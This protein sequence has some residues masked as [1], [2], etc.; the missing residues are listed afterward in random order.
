[1]KKIIAAVLIV[2][3]LVLV[4]LLGIFIHNK[5][6]DN[7]FDK[8]R[9]CVVFKDQSEFDKNGDYIHFLNT[10]SSD[11]IL[12]QSDNH[13]ALIDAGEDSDNPR[14]FDELAYEGSEEEVLNYLKTY[15]SDENGKVYFDFVLG[16]HAHSDHL[17]G[18]DTVLADC[19]VSADRAYLKEYDESK[20]RSHEV[21]RWD[22]KEVYQQM[23]SALWQKNIPVISDMD[24]EPFMLGNFKIT[25]FNTEVFEDE[26]DIG[27]N[28]N[29][30][31]VLVEKGSTRIFL[32]GDIDNI[33]GD[34]DRL[35]PQIKEVDLLKVGHH[36]YSKS[37]TSNW[38]STLN[39]KSCVVTNA[40]EKIDNRT[41]RRIT[42]ITHSP[43][44]ITGKENGVIAQIDDDGEISY[45]KDFML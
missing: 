2:I 34:E 36:S 28:D 42:R 19:A 25:L 38:L 9:A 24:G 43:V 35:A 23:L 15:A 40:F 41:I 45:F 14:G 37:T 31:G 1:M 32:S 18:F 5:M 29:S 17:G 16:T 22:N 39:P 10:D 44:L 7:E 3:I 26:K 20:I 13:F 21:E 8:N 33:S 11:A 6:L 30:L 27:E 4:V 12:L